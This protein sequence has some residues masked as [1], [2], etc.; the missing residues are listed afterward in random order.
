ML[1]Q[2]VTVSLLNFK[3][4]PNRFLPSM[5]VVVGIACVVGVLLSMLSLSTGYVA[6]EMKAGDPGR[7][8]IIADG[9]ENESASA[10]TRDQVNIIKDAP[11]IKKDVDGA[12]LA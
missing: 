10:L 6:S 9:I 8:I 4:I 2:I 3:S 5:V 12:P 1:G 11:G 7:A